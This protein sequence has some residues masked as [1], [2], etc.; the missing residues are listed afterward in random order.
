MLAFSAAI[1]ACESSEPLRDIA[2]FEGL[3]F[4]KSFQYVQACTE[5]KKAL[6]AKQDAEGLD[7]FAKST[8]GKNCRTG[9]DYSAKKEAEAL[10]GKASQLKASN[11][12]E[13]IKQAQN[14]ISKETDARWGEIFKVFPDWKSSDLNSAYLYV[15]RTASTRLSEIMIS[16]MRR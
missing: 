12:E 14:S 9:F 2:Y 10:R 5:E 16:N 4:E 8:R 3:G 1:T 7:K 15:A 11:T 6:L 13:E